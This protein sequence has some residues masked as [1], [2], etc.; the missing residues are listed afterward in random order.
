MV[1]SCCQDVQRSLMLSGPAKRQNHNRISVG[2]GTLRRVVGRIARMVR[3]RL[4]GDGRA[5]VPARMSA[6]ERPAHTDL[7]D[8]AGGAVLAGVSRGTCP[9]IVSR[10]LS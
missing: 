2:C 9:R 6:P 7:D 8:A 5:L 3:A 4:T 10:S 1:A